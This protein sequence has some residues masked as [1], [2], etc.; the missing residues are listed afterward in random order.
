MVVGSTAI[1]HAG[2]FGHGQIFVKTLTGKT[3]IID[4]G[5]TACG[6]DDMKLAVFDKTRIPTDQQR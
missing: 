2:T 3:I 6:V 1:G 4:A 5:D